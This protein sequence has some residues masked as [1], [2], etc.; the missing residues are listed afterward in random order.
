LVSVKAGSPVSP[1]YDTQ[2]KGKSEM[3]DDLKHKLVE[4]LKSIDPYKIILFGSHAYGVP[5][6]ASD[7]DLM[8]VTEDDFLPQ[9][10]AEKNEVYLRVASTIVEIEK[11]FPIDLIVHTRAMHQKFFEMGSQFSKKIAAE[12]K[13]LYE[14]AH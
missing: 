7:V 10:F 14:K 12:G 3:T 9:S 13:V 6:Q 2:R 11:E 4:R 5:N 1:D 8:V